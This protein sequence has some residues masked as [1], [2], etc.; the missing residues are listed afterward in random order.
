MSSPRRIDVHHHIVPPAYARWLRG[1]G[2]AA[3]GLPI[4]DWSAEASLALM[5]VRGI[6]T[7]EAK[8]QLMGALSELQAA[9]VRELVGAAG[10]R[11]DYRSLPALGHSLHGQDPAL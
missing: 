6:A 2:L 4:P 10:C 8:G 1:E 3:G 9:R 7:D 5:D 11:I